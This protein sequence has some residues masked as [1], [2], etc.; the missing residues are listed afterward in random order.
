MRGR[1]RALCDSSSL[2]A[3]GASGLTDRRN[4]D[5]APNIWVLGRSTVSKCGLSWRSLWRGKS[6][7]DRLPADLRVI[8]Q[9]EM[10]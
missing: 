1:S 6:G 2:S 7:I 4:G 9:S 10:V 3:K 8:G 5:L